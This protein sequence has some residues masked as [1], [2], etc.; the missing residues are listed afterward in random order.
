MMMGFITRPGVAIVLFM[1]GMALIPLNDS[2]IKL[3]SGRFSVFEI[4]A[5]RSA[6]ALLIIMAIPVTLKT[7]SQLSLRSWI[8][9]GGR[10]VCLV[11]AM[12]LFFLPLATLGLAEV[13][14]IFFTAPLLISVFSVPL[15]GEKLG[16]YRII[17]VL[18]GLAGVLLIVQPGGE[19]FQL[20]YLMPVGSAVAYAAFQLITR[21]LRN[22]AEL[23]AMVAVQQIVY[24]LTGVAGVIL[25]FAFQPEIPPG[26][27]W[28]FLLREWTRPELQDLVYLAIASVVVL[29][30]AFVSTNVYRNV[31]A[32]L[33]APFEYTAL[34]MAVL[35]GILIWGDWPLPTAWAGMGLILAGGIFMIYRENRNDT[36][37]ASSL[38]MRS[39]VTNKASQDDTTQD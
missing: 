2:L 16:I 33:V 19:R 18:A 35:W 17:A 3:M 9:L 30:L 31:E 7:L 27:V 14:S 25:I 37:I 4:L 34:P 1:F 12:L 26:E 5:V 32:T 13:T 21:Y 29:N 23:L 36:D 28:G 20:A 22:E 8:V 11:L 6:F 15:L 39:A 38:P 10:G 24:L